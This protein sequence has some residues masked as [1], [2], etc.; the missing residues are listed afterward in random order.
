MRKEKRK[1]IIFI[2]SC[3]VLSRCMMYLWFRIFHGSWDFNL[4]I[5]KM[6]I[7]DA[8]WYQSIATG[9][10]PRSASD[11]LLGQASW[12]FFPAYPVMVHLIW[13][14]FAIDVN[15]IAVILSTI[16][17]CVALYV[18]Y[19]YIILT[20]NNVHQGYGY[21]YFMTFGAY[22]FYYSIFYTE[23]LYLMLLSYA[24]YF[25]HKREYLKMGIAGALLSMT[26]NTGIFF[27]FVILA[28][29]I[30]EYRREW[31]ASIV[32]MVKTTAEKYR[33]I[34]G[35]MMVPLGFFSYMLYLKFRTGDAFAFLHVQRAWLRENIG[36]YK[37]VKSALLDEFPPNYLGICFCIFVYLLIVLIWKHRR[38]EE[39][40]LPII[41][42]AVSTCSSLTSIPRYM[43][44]SFTLALAF[45]DEW[46]NCSV[47][48]RGLICVA[49]GIFELL[50][51]N[52]WLQ[53]SWWLM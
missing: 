36:V 49:I 31:N 34:L 43:A 38:I 13:K 46:K 29:W 19:Q 12:A 2:L 18:G 27:C 32:L 15:Y 48:N 26:R 44:G 17:L 53:G 42:L 47:L 37:I 45:T 51:V 30:K 10:Y 20:R 23:S 52:A 21:I 4:F 9:L 22:S 5:Q 24:Y 41:T 50:C 16:F 33:L 40:V 6:N 28:H 8:G 3:V 25:M 7:W 1:I 39:A 14:A 35:T 11:T